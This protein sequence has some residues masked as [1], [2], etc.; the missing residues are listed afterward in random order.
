MWMYI[1]SI[2]MRPDVLFYESFVLFQVKTYGCQQNVENSKK[3]FPH[4]LIK[5]LSLAPQRIFFICLFGKFVFFFVFA[6]NFAVAPRRNVCSAYDFVWMDVYIFYYNFIWWNFY[7]WCF[8]WYFSFV[9]FTCFFL[10]CSYL[11]LIFRSLQ[12][13]LCGLTK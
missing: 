4:Q 10:F 13:A 2:F 8:M 1:C 7:F 9:R 6:I 11:F 3:Y 5:L 12:S